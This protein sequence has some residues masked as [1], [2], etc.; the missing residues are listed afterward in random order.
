[1]RAGKCIMA[2]TM[3]TPISRRDALK[4]AAQAGAGA[5]VAS[6]QALAQEKPIEI[7]GKPVEV[8][9]TQVTPQTV[10]ITIRPLE[11]G[12][13]KP[14]PLDGALVKEN[15]GQP[16]MVLRSFAGTRRVKS[17][18]LTVTLARDPFSVRVEGPGGRLIQE[19]Q[20]DPA[21]GKM[22]FTIGEG[23]V[24]GLGQG[25]PQF[26]KLGNLDRMG[27]GQGAFRLATHGA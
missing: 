24:L 5:L 4:S 27:S 10:R 11:S 25:G 3:K 22:T 9:V 26:D 12:T 16:A 21:T 19:L 18:T 15:F 7:A 20:P 23:P 14:V 17:G 8:A 13:P 6:S 1:M 2:Q